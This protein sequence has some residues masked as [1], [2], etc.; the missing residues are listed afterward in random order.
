M[1]ANATKQGEIIMIRKEDSIGRWISLL[2]RYGQIY[3]SRK[4][5]PYGIGKGQFMFLIK[6]FEKDGL[7][8]DELAESLNFDKGTTARALRKLEQEDY[9]VREK[10]VGD[11]RSNRVF[12]TG[13]ARDIK[14]ALF[15]VLGNWTEILATGFSTEE[16]QQVLRLLEK[17]ANNAAK[18][19]KAER[20]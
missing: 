13:K 20:E 4:M 7:S 19:A 18:L 8:Q 9:V 16:K 11:R 10:N 17:M 2:Y 14:P 15:T 6:L 3:M 12:L 5:Q 1:V